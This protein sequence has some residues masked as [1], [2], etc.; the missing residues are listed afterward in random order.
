L[1]NLN[2]R[3]ERHGG[4]LDVVNSAEGG[5]RLQWSIPIHL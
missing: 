2:R 3:A 4:Y 5:L 1:A